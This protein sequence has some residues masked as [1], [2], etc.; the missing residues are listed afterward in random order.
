MKKKILITL[1]VVLVLAVIIFFA[2]KFMNVKDTQKDQKNMNKN[3]QINAQDV[4]QEDDDIYFKVLK[5]EIKYVNE[6]NKET[7]FKEYMENY[8]ESTENPKIKYT[9]FDF[10]NDSK[11]EMIVMIEAFN[12]GFYLILNNED[13]TVY[14]FEEVYRGL[15]DLKTDGTY[16]AS[17]GAS[18][19]GILRD[20][21]EK[22]KRI[23]E[24]LAE[25]DM[26]KFQID[27]KDVS[28]EEYNKYLDEFSKK[29]M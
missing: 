12:D 17:G 29:K 22:N 11:N 9:V 8:K 5:N 10:D 13:G 23:Q 16:L 3:E 7:L 25:M 26:G 27:G 21:F 20:K 28:E 4:A 14:G 18:S 1:I 19:N 6:D 15:K 2:S 24:T